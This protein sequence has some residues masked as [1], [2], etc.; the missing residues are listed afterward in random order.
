M[1]GDGKNLVD[2][3]KDVMNVDVDKWMALQA[4]HGAVHVGNVGLK[5]TWFGPKYIS[6]M[7]FKWMANK[8]RYMFDIGG[9]LD[10]GGGPL[11]TSVGDVDG[12]PVAHT[13]W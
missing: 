9:G 8:P 1:F 13:G 10:F 2:Y 5:Y 3:G 6:N 11:F 12:K 4:I 7:Y